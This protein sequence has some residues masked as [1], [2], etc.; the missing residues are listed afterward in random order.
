M[1]SLYDEL[2]DK[3]KRDPRPG[4]PGGARADIGLLLYGFRDELRALWVAA[5]RC[6]AAERRSEAG[7]GEEALSELRG[8]V[9]A[10]ARLF[11]EREG[12]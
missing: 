8:A 2:S 4:K 10:L 7:G 5:D 3:L 1:I 6:S 12:G 11:G 9:E